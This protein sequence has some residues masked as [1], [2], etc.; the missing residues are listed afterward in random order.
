MDS[1]FEFT[2]MYLYIVNF[3][4]VSKTKLDSFLT[5]GQFKLYKCIG[6]LKEKIYRRRVEDYFFYVNRKI[7]FKV[8]KIKLLLSDVQVIPAE[9]NSKKQK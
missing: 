8:L 1:L 9:I 3:R 4:A 6:Y 7:P 5:T 2:I